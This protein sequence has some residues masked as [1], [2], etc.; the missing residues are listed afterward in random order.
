MSLPTILVTDPEQRAALAAT[1][2]LG[3]NGYK[4]ISVGKARGLAGLS[5]SCHQHERLSA[6]PESD[7]DGYIAEIQAVILRTK[8]DVVLPVTDVASRV[9]LGAR[10]RLG[11][12]VA[13]PSFSA[14]TMASNKEYLQRMAAECGI[15]TPRQVVLTSPDD[16]QELTQTLTPPL[17]VKSSN[18]VVNVGGVSVKP[19][20]KMV[21]TLGEL[22]MTILQ[23]PR[24][25]FPL[26][27]QERTI[28]DGVGV[29]LLRANGQTLLTLGHRRL[30]EK[31]PSGGV[32]TYR[33]AI[34]P[35]K[36]LQQKCE[37]LLDRL[38]YEGAA[39]IE[40][41]Q[42][43]RTGEYLLMEINARLWGSLQLAS[44][45]GVDFAC[46][47][48]AWTLGRPLPRHTRAELGTRTFWE[49]GE[50]DHAI[51]L[52]TKSRACLHVPSEMHVGWRAAFHVFWDHQLSDRRE[53][54]RWSDPLPFMN[55]CIGWL[56]RR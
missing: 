8:A 2:A 28:G 32:S 34:Q 36:E 31:P 37:L 30:R 33:E 25:A 53:I 17:V 35:P 21:D 22:Q 43:D 13:G 3:K 14:Y 42:D 38:K 47:L 56:L 9:L 1:R 26:L 19:P 16:V 24:E 12:A 23:Y 18:S 29:F 39:M 11:T 20:V 27:V 4:V 46:G 45:A 54:F 41:K 50:L 40:F 7:Q 6:N 48:V 5:R 15:H 10:T 51:A 52:A 44:D 55:E 49:L